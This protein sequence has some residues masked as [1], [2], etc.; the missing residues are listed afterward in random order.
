MA[1]HSTHSA[2]GMYRWS[3]CPGSI[4][5]CDTVPVPVQSAYAAE[6]TL[7]HDLAAKL[8]NGEA[9]HCDDPGMFE[10]ITEYVRVVKAY[11]QQPECR[12][13][14]E[15]KFD[16]SSVYPGCFGTADFVCHWPMHKKLIVIDYKHGAGVW[17]NPA[18]NPQLLYYGLGAV[19]DLQL[20]DVETVE[21][22]ICQPRCG[23]G[24]YRSIE[25]SVVDLLDFKHDLVM[26]AT[27]TEQADA[28]LVIGDHC[29]FCP[30]AQIDKKTGDAYCPA[31]RDQRRAVL[32]MEFKQ[33]LSY[34]PK[35]LAQALDARE[36]V[37]AWLKNL[38]EFAYDVM[39]HG[40][41]IPGYKIVEKKATRKW[42]DEPAALSMLKAAGYA[43]G[44]ILEAPALKSPAQLEKTDKKAYGAAAAFVSKESSGHVIAP[45][46]DKRPAVR[47]SAKEEFGA[48]AET[49]DVFA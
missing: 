44:V 16:L 42:T 31:V 36:T 38:D 43:D 14:V 26:Y 35:T 21:L 10:A 37:K 40:A 12:W 33:E 1:A 28:P 27:A 48:I 29:R 47:P 7:A 49:V 22:G 5:L 15:R 30:A 2:S 23:D 4:K 11:Q 8:L 24:E 39:E 18:N 19:I 32:Q 41:Q 6:G 25:I 34:D 17:V 3:A 9:V 46:S 13:W 45:E 20:P